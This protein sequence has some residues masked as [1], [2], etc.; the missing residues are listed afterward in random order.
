MADRHYCEHMSCADDSKKVSNNEVPAKS[1][2]CMLHARYRKTV[3]L[4][5]DGE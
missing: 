1:A 5:E 4:K 3:K 2:T